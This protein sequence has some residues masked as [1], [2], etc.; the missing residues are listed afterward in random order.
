LSGNVFDNSPNGWDLQ[1]GVLVPDH[2][3]R[4]DPERAVLHKLVEDGL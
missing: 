1:A 3:C 4:G 2:E